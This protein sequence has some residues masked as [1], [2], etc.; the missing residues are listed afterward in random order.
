MREPARGPDRKIELHVRGH[1]EEHTVRPER[2]VKCLEL[3]LLRRQNLR[4]EQFFEKTH[5]L[6]YGGP[7]RGEDDPLLLER[8][9]EVDVHDVAVDQ[10]GV[11]R[12]RKVFFHGSREPGRTG[13]VFGR[14]SIGREP[15]VG[16]VHHP[17]DI[18]VPPLFRSRARKGGVF[19]HRPRVASALTQ[20]RRGTL[21]DTF[22]R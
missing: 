15:E 21:A 6:V 1:V 14:H 3:A 2:G 12:G 17:G 19:E 4:S 11:T 9:I 22:D 5:V 16:E 7:K 10:H 8:G 13:A 20:P 18:G